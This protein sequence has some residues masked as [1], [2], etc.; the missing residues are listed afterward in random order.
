MFG[1]HFFMW[2]RLIRARNDLWHCSFSEPFSQLKSDVENAI[3]TAIKSLFYDRINQK[4]IY[5]SFD[6]NF[7]TVFRRV[8][9]WSNLVI[10]A[11]LFWNILASLQGDVLANL[12]WYILG[13][14]LTN[15][16]T[17]FPWYS[18]KLLLW[19]ILA[20]LSYPLYCI[21]LLGWS[22]VHKIWFRL[23]ADSR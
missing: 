17:L 9:N 20:L 18:A 6:S 23:K 13:L 11:Y 21:I 19:N 14:L 16:D 5:A 4:L 22:I 2:R 15:I 10:F 8:Q 7:L 12:A 1:T 3:S